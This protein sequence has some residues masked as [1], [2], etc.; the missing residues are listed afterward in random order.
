MSRDL[1]EKSELIALL[2]EEMRETTTVTILFH[3]AIADRLEVPVSTI[4]GRLKR[5]RLELRDRLQPRDREG[6]RA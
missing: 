6:R 3:Q 5:A 4:Q 1:R 2:M